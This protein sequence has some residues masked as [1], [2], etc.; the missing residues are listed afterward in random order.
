MNLSRGLW[1]LVVIALLVALSISVEID[2]HSYFLKF[3]LH[4]YDFD[5][6][7]DY[8]VNVELR[9]NKNQL[10]CAKKVADIIDDEIY[11]AVGTSLLKPGVNSVQAIFVNTADGEIID[12][13]GLL[14]QAEPSKHI[15]ANKD[16]VVLQIPRMSLIAAGVTGAALC[17][18]GMSALMSYTTYR[19][20]PESDSDTFEFSNDGDGDDW[21]DDK[22]QFKGHMKLT[23]R[24]VPYLERSN[25]SP[26]IRIVDPSQLNS[27]KFT[28]MRPES[29][30][31]A[32]EPYKHVVAATV[33]FDRGVQSLNSQFEQF[34]FAQQ[35]DLDRIKSEQDRLFALYDELYSQQRTWQQE[36]RHQPKKLVDQSIE[37]DQSFIA[38]PTVSPNIAG[39]LDEDIGEN[40]SICDVDSLKYGA[41]GVYDERESSGLI[42][43]SPSS[44]K[45]QNTGFRGRTRTLLRRALFGAGAIALAWSTLQSKSN[46][47]DDSERLPE[48]SDIVTFPKIFNVVKAKLFCR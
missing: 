45:V 35:S 41:D 33:D 42:V 20:S 32:S 12:T 3:S 13:I 37:K 17:G 38:V 19:R 18:Y 44:N 27:I 47:E 48:R 46:L 16:Y 31:S 6:L 26:W 7:S 36:Q 39:T 8:V 10:L 28:T 5:K 11:C 30:P 43:N 34:K 24:Q 23:S 1:N 29:V 25:R 14:I 22:G 2:P 4:D 15:R 9:N 21:D 40:N